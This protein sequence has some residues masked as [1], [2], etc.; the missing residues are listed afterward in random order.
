MHQRKQSKKWNR[1]GENIEYFL[2][3]P[4]ESEKIFAKHMSNKGLMS[5]IYKELNSII[6]RQIT[7]FENRKELNRY[8]SKKDIQQANRGME[9][10]QH[11]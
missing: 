6:K 4:I 9:S 11:H 8:F 10:C 1:I 5:K 3:S 2:Y 7:W